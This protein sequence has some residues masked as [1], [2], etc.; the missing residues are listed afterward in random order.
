MAAVH[1]K[2]MALLARKRP[3]VDP[4]TAAPLPP[5]ILDLTEPGVAVHASHDR[6]A[7]VVDGH[8]VWLT[9]AEVNT[10]R[11]QLMMASRAVLTYN[12]AQGVPQP[13]RS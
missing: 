5:P 9:L 8:L 7:L 10:L 13:R 6:V 1:N 11:H 3:S 2:C 12:T 4:P